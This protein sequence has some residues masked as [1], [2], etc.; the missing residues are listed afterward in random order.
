MGLEKKKKKYGREVRGKIRQSILR[1]GGGRG[2]G[3]KGEGLS[4]LSKGLAQRRR[5]QEI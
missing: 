4:Q 3:L 2:Q 1:E 5:I